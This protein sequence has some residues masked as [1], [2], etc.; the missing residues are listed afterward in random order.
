MVLQVSCQKIFILQD[1]AQIFQDWYDHV[2]EF[3]E[4]PK[5]SRKI[6]V[7]FGLEKFSI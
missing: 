4:N 6:T 5:R 7:G 2:E 3:C 1:L